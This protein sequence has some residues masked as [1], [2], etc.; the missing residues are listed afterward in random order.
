MMI[1][2]FTFYLIFIHPNVT[3]GQEIVQDFNLDNI[4]DSLYYKCYQVQDSI[5]TPTCKIEI[6]LGKSNKINVYYLGYISDAMIGS[7]GKGNIY[8]FDSSKDTEYTKEY[9]Y[10]KKY[11]DWILTKDEELLKY[12][13]N[14]EINNLPKKYLLGIS[15]K[16]Y[17]TQKRIIRKKIKNN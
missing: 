5:N 1:K 17:P 8:L 6:K 3:F 11:R 14:K 7:Y 15:G 13:N 2:L 4:K 10:S 9:N 16:K 12:E